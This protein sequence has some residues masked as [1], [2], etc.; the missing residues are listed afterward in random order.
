MEL[1]ID[2]VEVVMQR[3]QTRVFALGLSL[4]LLTATA[5]GA[6]ASTDAPGPRWVEPETYLSHEEALELDAEQIA[7]QTGMPAD[8]VLHE[9]E[10]APAVEKLVADARELAGDRFA[11]AWIEREPTWHLRVALTAG[12]PVALDALVGEADVPVEIEYREG[13]SEEI[14]IEEADLLAEWAAATP[15]IDGVGSNIQV[16][17]LVVYANDEAALTSRGLPVA[18]SSGIA[19]RFVSSGQPAASEAVLR[20]GAAA[21]TCT[22]GFTVQ[23]NSSNRGFVTAGH[24]GNS[25]S[26]ASTPTGSP[27]ASSTFG[28]EIHSATADIQYHRI[29]SPH[30]TSNTFYGSSSSTA[31][32]RNGTGVA[33]VGLHLC[34]RGK[35]TG[36]SCG[37]VTDTT[38]A[39]TWNG[40]CGTATCRAVFV[41]VDGLNLEGSPGDSGGPWFRGG[42]AY[43]IHMGGGA[44]W[45]VY[46][47]IARISSLSVS[48]M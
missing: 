40:A 13:P 45:K 43:G 29:T 17:E 6:V 7:S 18:P 12:G 4:G 46:T 39:P 16:P 30:S 14:L 10:L 38:F 15:G 11:G 21:S 35:V 25:Q 23:A 26:W 37:N 8:D 20:G 27:G 33:T 22:T 3:T 2:A 36:S 24:C 34:H 32:I 9:L 42:A 41:R 1:P 44:A 31:T 47:P 19:V 5:G 48:L 28:G